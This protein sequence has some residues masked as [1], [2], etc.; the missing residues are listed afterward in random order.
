MSKM[1][2]PSTEPVS[3]DLFKNL[4]AAGAVR[5]VVVAAIGADFNVLIHIGAH[6]RPL[7]TFRGNVRNFKTIQTVLSTLH[8]FGVTHF[9]VDV[10]EYKPKP[11]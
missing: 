11:R 10:T 5:G 1:P 9:E 3:P 6:L 7:A 4:T 2:L 8:E